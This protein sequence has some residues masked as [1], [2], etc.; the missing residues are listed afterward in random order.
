MSSPLHRESATGF[1]PAKGTTVRT[2]DGED[3]GSVKELR[4]Q[5]FRV[6]A[7][8]A[9]DYWLS[10]AQVLRQD[11]D[12]LVMDFNAE[13]ADDYAMEEPMAAAGSPALDG[14]AATFGSTEE[15][16]ETREEMEGR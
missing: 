8:H 7:P 6:D 4:G 15:I 1:E 3:L 9:R 5:A 13:V 14:E 11:H 12:V 2:R 16:E 10:L